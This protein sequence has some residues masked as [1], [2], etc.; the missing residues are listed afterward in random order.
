MEAHVLLADF[1]QV[2]AAGKVNALGLGWSVTSTPAPNHAVVVMVRVGWDET[3][4][5]HHL[6][7]SLLTADGL[8]AVEIATP[9]G[10]QPLQVE[11]DFEVGR[12]P[13]LPPGSTI[14]HAVAINVGQGLPLAPGRY[15]WR[16]RIGDHERDDWRAAFLVRASTS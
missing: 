5:S 3:N 13:G 11:M 15:E 6:S 16:M 2:D 10:S 4:I 7:L 8:H 1:A 14:D 9:V 12:P